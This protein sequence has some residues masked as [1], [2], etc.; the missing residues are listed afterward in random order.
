MVLL[1]QSELSKVFFEATG[2]YIYLTKIINAIWI[3]HKR[4]SAR[5]KLYLNHNTVYPYLE[6]I[7][8]TQTQTR[9]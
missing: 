2:L 7:L 6:C 3:Q 9:L 1:T 8:S 5:Y 4:I